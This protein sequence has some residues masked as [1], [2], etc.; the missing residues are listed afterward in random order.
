M[1]E[2][3]FSLLLNRNKISNSLLKSMIPRRSFRNSF[4]SLSGLGIN[5]TIQGI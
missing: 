3:M 4:V 1:R 2:R 5:K